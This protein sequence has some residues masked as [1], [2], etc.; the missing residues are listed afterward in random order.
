VIELRS[1][2]SDFLLT[3]SLTARK[4]AEVVFTRQSEARIP[5]RLV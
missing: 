2:A 3:E 4:G 5:R 1:T